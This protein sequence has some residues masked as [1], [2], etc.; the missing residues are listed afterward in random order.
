MMVRV[1][2]TESTIHRSV[3]CARSSARRSAPSSAR[4]APSM[5]P[6][7]IRHRERCRRAPAVVPGSPRLSASGMSSAL[8]ASRSGRVLGA[9]MV[10]KRWRRTCASVAA[11]PPIRAMARASSARRTRRSGSTMYVSSSPRAP[12]SRA[13]VGLSS[14]RATASA[15]SSAATRSWSTSPIAVG[16]TPLV[17]VRTALPWASASPR[18]AA[19]RA[20]SSSVSRW[21]RSPARRCASPRP[22]SSSTCRPSSG[23]P[24]ATARRSSAW[25]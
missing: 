16:Q 25:W 9:G 5:S 22:M 17:L 1:V 11:S 8:L 12:R 7:S 3:G 4:S 21:A 6:A 23:R 14:G 10:K 19:R 20:A 24:S 13:L 2:A 18:S 15:A